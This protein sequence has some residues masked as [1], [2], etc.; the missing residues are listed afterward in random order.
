M[1]QAVLALAPRV[2]TTASRCY[3]LTDV[4]V[5][6]FDKGGIALP[7]AYRKY[8][9]DPFHGPEYHTVFDPHEASTPVGLHHLRIEPLW[10]RHPTQLWHGAFGLTPLR[11]Q[12]RAHVGQQRSA[13]ILEAIGQKQR[14][15]VRR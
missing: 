10:Q 1:L 4:E 9:R 13:V 6:A 11:L 3:P 15:T 2:D 5:Q 8:L 7:A 12:P 14:D